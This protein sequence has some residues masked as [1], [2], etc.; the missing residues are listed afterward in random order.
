LVFIYQNIKS[1]HS[2]KANIVF[3]YSYSRY[4]LYF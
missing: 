3:R 4:C 2:S 1:V